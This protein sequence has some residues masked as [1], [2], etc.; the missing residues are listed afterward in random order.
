VSDGVGAEILIEGAGSPIPQAAFSNGFQYSTSAGLTGDTG[1]IIIPQRSLDGLGFRVKSPMFT[2]DRGSTPSTSGSDIPTLGNIGIR[3]RVMLHDDKGVKILPYVFLKEDGIQIH[4]DDYGEGDGPL[5]KI[6]LTSVLY[7]WRKRGFT[8]YVVGNWL[9][10]AGEQ[11]PGGSGGTRVRSGG[12][13]TG[14]FWKH[15]LHPKHKNP[16]SFLDT[17]K[18]LLPRLPGQ[19]TPGYINKTIRDELVIGINWPE[20][21]PFAVQALQWVMDQFDVIPSYNPFRNELSFYLRG[22]GKVG[23]GLDNGSKIPEDRIAVSK[24][25]KAFSFPLEAVEIYGPPALREKRLAL[26]PVGPEI[27]PNPQTKLEADKSRTIPFDEWLNKNFGIGVITAGRLITQDAK[28]V[29][30]EL[31]EEKGTLFGKYAFKMFRLKPEDARKYLPIED[32]VKINESDPKG[33]PIRRDIFIRAPQH[34]ERPKKEGSGRPL[35]PEAIKAGERE[36]GGQGDRWWNDPDAIVAGGVTIDK[37]RGHFTFTKARGILK[38]LSVNSYPM[39]TLVLRQV[40][41]TF[42]YRDKPGFDGEPDS[43][44]QAAKR[45]FVY[46][47]E[48]RGGKAVKVKEFTSGVVPTPVY[49]EELQLVEE[50]DGASNEKTLDRFAKERAKAMLENRPDLIEGE[51]LMVVGFSDTSLNGKVTGI[52]WACDGKTAFTSIQAAPGLHG[53]GIRFRDLLGLSE[54]VAFGLAPVVS[55]GVRE[56][57]AQMRAPDTNRSVPKRDDIR[58]H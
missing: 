28:V 29:T 21:H 7:Y 27:T 53:S 46:R 51:E 2:P 43:P 10:N 17:I 19:V 24:R 23:T 35:S 18:Y 48:R 47:S 52:T 13:S 38:D 36:F 56:R 16:W 31:G 30:Q 5:V 55:Q 11:G 26:E 32:R 37:Q 8:G 50:L 4:E 45:R 20:E 57:M 1:H 58:R 39:H 9:K 54:E 42:A 40:Y 22:E 14:D 41:A 34:G 33:P 15:T 44:E 49:V 6:E 25:G 3:A 12:L